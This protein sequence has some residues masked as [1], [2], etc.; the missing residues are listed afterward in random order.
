[1]SDIKS[2]ICKSEN[3][4]YGEV[5]FGNDKPGQYLYCK[6]EH[7]MLTGRDDE[8]LLRGVLDIEVDCFEP[9]PVE[10]VTDEGFFS[11]MESVYIRVRDNKEKLNT[12][13]LHLRNCHFTSETQIR[14]MF[15]ALECD[16]ME[17]LFR[18]KMSGDVRFDSN[19]FQHAL[20]NVGR[21]F[22]HFREVQ[23]NV[24]PNKVDEAYENLVKKIFDN[25]CG[26]ERIVKV[27]IR[28]WDI[29]CCE[30]FRKGQIERQKCPTFDAYGAGVGDLEGVIE[31]VFNCRSLIE[32]LID[33]IQLRKWE[34]RKLRDGIARTPHKNLR[35]LAV[36]RCELSSEDMGDLWEDIYENQY[37]NG[38]TEIDMSDNG[39]C[40]PSQM[41]DVL[42]KMELGRC[43]C[44]KV[45]IAFVNLSGWEEMHTSSLGKATWCECTWDGITAGSGTYHQCNEHNKKMLYMDRV[46]RLVGLIPES[47]EKRRNFFRDFY[48]PSSDLDESDKEILKNKRAGVEC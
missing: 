13:A 47:A 30:E 16:G 35:K 22:K 15:Q 42:T 24:I 34:L 21:I 1:M 46:E 36:T 5:W 26:C 7:R 8:V 23:F 27:E 40:K 41:L 38:L 25:E 17:C 43:V 6:M 18:L 2:T 45:N 31:T 32:I 9:P 14:L 4:R 20:T 37:M 3:G 10:I 12:W 39:P 28:H 29:Q 44:P 19:A 11:L 33:G 48:Y